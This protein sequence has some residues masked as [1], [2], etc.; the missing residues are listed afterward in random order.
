MNTRQLNT[1]WAILLVATLATWTIGEVGEHLGIAGPPAMLTLL[2]ISFVKGRL[3]VL[4]FM[5]LR[6]VKFFWRS[7]VIGWLLLV[8]ALIAIAYWIALK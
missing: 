3:V 7:L 2:A 1:V 5:G 4:D 8:S 6:G